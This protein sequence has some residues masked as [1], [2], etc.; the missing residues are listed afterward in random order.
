MTSKI[1]RFVLGGLA[2]ALAGGTAGALEAPRPSAAVPVPQARSTAVA[3]KPAEMTTGSIS[4][5]TAVAS[6]AALSALENG[7]EALRLDRYGEARA[8]R[9]AMP[10]GSLDRDVLTWALAYFGG[11]NMPSSE[12]AAAARRLSDW[13]GMA[14]LRE[15]SERALARE[16]PPA[17]TV[18]AAFGQTQPQT[19]E[20]A[21][22]LARAHLAGGNTKAAHAVIAPFW[23]ETKLEAADEVSAL[24]TFG[25]VLTRDDHRHRMEYMLY[26]DRVRSA[27]RVAE[28]AGAA[29]LA[30][31]WGAVVRRAGN[32]GALLDAVPKSQRSAGYLFARARYLRSKE[33]FREAASVINQAPRERAALIDPDQWWAERRVLSRELLDQGDRQLAY[34]VAAAHAAESPDKAAEAEFH[35]GWYALRAIGDA[36]TA[37]RH[38]ARILD[39]A[40]GPISRARA[41]YWLGRAAE[42][43]ADGSSKDYYHRAAQY[44][45]AFYGQLAAARIGMAGVAVSYPKPSDTDRVSFAQRRAVAAIGRLEEAGQGWRANVLYQ[46]LAEELSSVGELALLAVAAE[47]SGNHRMALK[48]GKTA[49]ARGLDVGAMSHPLGA[50]PASADISGAGKALAYAIARQESEFFAGAVSPAGARGLLQ[51]MPGTAKAVAKRVGLGYSQGR[52]TSDPA[53]NA[54]LGAQFLKEQLERFNGSYVL[55]FAAYNAGPNRVQQWIERYGDPRGKSVAEIVDWIER[56]PYTETRSYVQRVMENYQVYRMRLSGE[57]DIERDLTRGR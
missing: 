23:R 35:A 43:G 39:I 25:S 27:E 28:L 32:A 47:N 19:W 10:S 36:K 1:Q 48:I 57:F 7:L 54:T 22:A 34:Q 3:S 45:T 11:D 29:K 5:V 37:H 44:G 30:E 13:P 26:E 31:A 14:R 33:R 51:L 40:D 56:I 42:A 46:Q 38:F 2:L 16:N 24:K 41:Y 49:A 55:T 15:N 20:G 52:L 21:A 18:L 4:R 50:I 12:I 8:I 53:Y 6:P 9:D 17:A